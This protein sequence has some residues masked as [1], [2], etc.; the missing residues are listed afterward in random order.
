MSTAPDY[1]PLSDGEQQW[2]AGHVEYGRTL[3]I[4][5]SDPRSI[6][7]F[8]DSS[9][10]AIESGEQSPE[11]ANAVVNIVAVLLGE[12]LCDAS[13]L[14][15]SIVTD[16]FGTDLCVRGP[17]TSKVFFPQSSVAK[18]WEAGETGW[19]LPFVSWVNEQVN[20]APR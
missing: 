3:G 5:V 1:T 11:D 4:E 2:I 6:S 14:T 19:V 15:W 16:E 20:G 13:N 18:R 17:D 12:H 10:R 7:Q 9:F 8:F